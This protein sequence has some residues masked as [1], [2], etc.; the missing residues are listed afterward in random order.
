LAPSPS[1]R[2]SLP[3]LGCVSWCSLVLT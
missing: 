3:L 1:Y 2:A